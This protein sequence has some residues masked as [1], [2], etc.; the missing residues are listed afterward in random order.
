METTVKKGISFIPKNEVSAEA[1]T[2]LNKLMEAKKER[3]TKLV[4]A[5]RKGELVVQK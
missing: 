1:K 2:K 5:Y 4:E 3:L